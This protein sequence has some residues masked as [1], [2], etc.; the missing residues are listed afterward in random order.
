MK[1]VV[2]TGASTGIGKTTALRLSQAGFTVFACVRKEADASALQQEMDVKPL[3]LDVTNESH[4]QAVV[5]EVEEVVGEAGLWGLVNNAGIVVAGPLEFLPVAE[6][7]KQFEVNVFAQ[8]AVTQAFMPL[9]RKAT[10]RIVMMSSIA[11]RFASPFLGP[12]AASKFAL[13]G[14]SDALRRELKEWKMF[15]S[16]VEPGRV[17]T[18]IW[19][20]S[21]HVAE[22]TSKQL[23]PQAQTLYG[24]KLNLMRE[25]AKRGTTQGVSPDEVARAVEHALMATRPKI[26][27]VVGPDAKVATLLIRVLPN[28]LLDWVGRQRAD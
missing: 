26:R 5:E 24:K 7:R 4:I 23:P 28:R 13:E 10:G 11:G 27:Y 12:Y 1:A 19:E 8:I 20:K 15:V 14:F 16:L 2:I 22:V 21:V 3:L 18:P 9:L 25:R 17:V 6:L